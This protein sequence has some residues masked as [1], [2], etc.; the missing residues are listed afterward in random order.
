[1]NRH[2]KINFDLPC[3]LAYCKLFRECS[4][5]RGT[6]VAQA[7]PRARLIHSFPSLVQDP[8]RYLYL[9]LHNKGVPRRV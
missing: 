5:L 1:M 9:A 7:G 2:R 4:E 3:I 6:R 8:V